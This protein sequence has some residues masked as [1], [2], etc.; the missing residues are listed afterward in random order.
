VSRPL[1]LHRIRAGLY[2]DHNNHVRIE[3]DGD[4]WVLVIDRSWV[5]TEHT[6]AACVAK[7]HAE[8]GRDL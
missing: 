2:I 5:T 3:F 4:V 6:K 8:L 1:R 7:A